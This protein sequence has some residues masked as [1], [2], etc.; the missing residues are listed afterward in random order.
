MGPC[1]GQLARSLVRLGLVDEY[2][3]SV[4]PVVVGAGTPLFG[5]TSEVA[6]LQLA[7][8]KALGTGVMILSYRRHDPAMSSASRNRPIP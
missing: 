8:T 1:G 4:H 6:A 3:L 5:D 2:R 7:D